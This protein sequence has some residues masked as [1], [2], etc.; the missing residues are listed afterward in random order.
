MSFA[1]AMDCHGVE[2]GEK[3]RDITNENME[4]MEKRWGKTWKLLEHHMNIWGKTMENMG[5]HHMIDWKINE[6]HMNE[7]RSTAS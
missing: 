2:Y 6:N 4:D 3:P 7:W 1:G 5:I